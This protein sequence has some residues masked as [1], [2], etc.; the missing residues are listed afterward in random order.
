MITDVLKV[1]A[2]ANKFYA[3]I[4]VQFGDGREYGC[5]AIGGDRSAKF[6][7]QL[8][9][10][11]GNIPADKRCYELALEKITRLAEHPDHWS[12]FESR[13]PD[14]WRYGG[15]IR[16]SENTSST[17][18]FMAWSGYPELP[19][20]AFMLALAVRSGIMTVRR[21]EMIALKSKNEFFTPVLAAMGYV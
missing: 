21:A 7:I 12:S 2:M 16:L 1:L 11:F 18:A 13:N 17:I 9:V 8:R 3:P 5:L 14:A 4:G 19:D 15:A 6:P 10:P 20:E